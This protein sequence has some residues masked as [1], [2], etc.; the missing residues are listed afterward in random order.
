MT[1]TS[2]LNVPS[3]SAYTQFQIRSISSQSVTIPCSM[4]YFILSKP[5]NSCA[6]RPMKTSPSNAPAMTRMCFG[7]PTLQCIQIT[8]GSNEC[9]GRDVQR[10][11]ETFWMILTGKSSFYSSRAL[12]IEVTRMSLW[13][14]ELRCNRHDSRTLSM[15]TG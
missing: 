1:L 3:S 11:E 2:S 5:R 4:G 9:K 8:V 6:R 10:R 13:M 15:T 12:S 14:I 7:R